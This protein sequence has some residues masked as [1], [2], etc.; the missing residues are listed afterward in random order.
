MLGD[1]LNPIPTPL[2]EVKKSLEPVE[3]EGGGEAAA[4]PAFCSGPGD[5]LFMGS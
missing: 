5:T 2:G 4:S 1:P 3:R